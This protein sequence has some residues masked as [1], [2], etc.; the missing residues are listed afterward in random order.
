MLKQGL[1]I[2][3]KLGKL[4]VKAQ[5]RRVR[6]LLLLVYVSRKSEAGRQGTGF[7][8]IE[9]LCVVWTDGATFSKIP[10]LFRPHLQM[11]MCCRLVF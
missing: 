5:F 4:S 1:T 10:F 2:N 8:V 7:I 3:K 11:S 9:K 6:M